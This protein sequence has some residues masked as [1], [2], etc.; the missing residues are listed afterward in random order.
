MKYIGLRKVS[1]SGFDSPGTVSFPS[2]STLSPSGEEEST[3]S[4]SGTEGR[5]K[6]VSEVEGEARGGKSG[7]S[8]PFVSESVSLKD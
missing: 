1:L 8:L 4:P 3:P 5:L 2:V 7:K 6:L